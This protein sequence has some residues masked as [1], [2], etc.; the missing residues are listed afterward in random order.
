[1]ETKVEAGSKPIRKL[2]FCPFCQYSRSNDP[3][4]MNHI[5]CGHYSA[6]YG[7]G[8]CLHEVY[9]TGQPLHKHMQTYKGLPK[10]ATD[11]VTADGTDS[12]TT[13]SQK[14]SRSE[15]LPSDLQPPPQGSQGSLQVSL[16]CSQHTKKKEFAPTPKK[17]GS[18]SKSSSKKEE[19][20]SSS[21]KHCGKGKSS[22]DKSGKPSKDKHH[23]KD[24]S[25]KD[26]SRKKKK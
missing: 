15:D 4:H 1:M 16:H 25:S 17:S 9:I 10:E 12:I 18:S 24:K 7:Y 22:K 21:H 3:S 19:K 14:K 26:K 6:N 13:L 23:G 5:I 8:N 2:S 11:K 20:R